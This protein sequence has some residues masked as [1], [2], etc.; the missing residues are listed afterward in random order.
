MSGDVFLHE[1]VKALFVYHREAVFKRLANMY[2]DWGA[3][4]GRR[5]L[6]ISKRE[7]IAVRPEAGLSRYLDVAWIVK[8]LNVKPQKKLVPSPLSATSSASR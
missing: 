7:L 6:P 3:V 2:P 1:I 8:G 4:A 5:D